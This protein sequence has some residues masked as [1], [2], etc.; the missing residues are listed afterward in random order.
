MN[1]NSKEYLA[2]KISVLGSLI[3]GL[4]GVLASIYANSISLLFD[5]FYSL[6]AMLIS[7]VGLRIAQLLKVKYSPK[8]NFGFYAL[9]PFFVLLNGILL[10]VL[11]ISLFIP[12]V[13]AILNGGRNIEL[14][15]VL[16]YLIFCVVF[17]GIFTIILKIYAQ[18]TNSHII[19]TDAATWLFDTLISFAVLVAFFIT[20]LL[21]NTPWEFLIPYTDPGITI[22]LILSLIYQPIKFIISGL[23]GLLQMSPGE[24]V[25]IEIKE[26][27][28]KSKK[29]L[30]FSDIRV[31]ASKVGRTI[32]VEIHCLYASDFEIRNIETIE[33]IRNEIIEL[34]QSQYQDMNVKVLFEKI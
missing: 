2:I 3:M 17:C 34:I 22:V 21:H 24:K 10:M 25:L 28:T 14:D 7:I 32:L 11:A 30:G 1:L 6:T 8:F 18:K 29:H 15:V 27:I 16:E 23:S 9:E 4:T 19:S 5:A 20:Y 31:L 12:S 26:T 33:N 13:K